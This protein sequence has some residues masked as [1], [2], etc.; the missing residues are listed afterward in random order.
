MNNEFDYKKDQPGQGNE[1]PQVPVQPPVTE[2]KKEP[3]QAEI[4][5][6]AFP[7]SEQEVLPRQ[8][9]RRNRKKPALSFRVL[10]RRLL[11]NPPIIRRPVNR[12]IRLL[13][14]RNTRN[15]N[16]VPSTML[17]SRSRVDSLVRTGRLAG[18]NGKRKKSRKIKWPVLWWRPLPFVR[19]LLW[20]LAGSAGRWSPP[21]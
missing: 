17:P 1:A 5:Q 19:S 11:R 9:R 3:I 16:T 14:S 21:I 15:T 13:H 10:L 2:E 6:T 12:S 18:K 4:S 8:Q 20:H 7:D